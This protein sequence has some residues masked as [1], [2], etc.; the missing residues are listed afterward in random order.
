MEPAAE[1]RTL[2]NYYL[3]EGLVRSVGDCAASLLEKAPDE[4]LLW[5]ALSLHLEGS[6]QVGAGSPGADG[7]GGT[8]RRRGGRAANSRRA[9]SASLS[10][11]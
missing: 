11:A 1:I 4:L 7:P 8:P 6:A 5:R 3:R 10:A 9:C 2:V